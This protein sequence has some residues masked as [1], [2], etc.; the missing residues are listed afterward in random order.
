MSS[1][2]CACGCGEYRNMYDSRGRE[3]RYIKGHGVKDSQ[4]HFWKGGRIIREGYILILV[5]KHPNADVNGY[6]K[7]HRF[8]M[9]Q[10]LGR[11]L[12][13]DEDVHHINGIKDDNRMENLEL[14]KHS[15]HS[16]ITN[17]K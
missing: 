10:K 15:E 17:T 3:T 12:T 13:K 11:Y 4:N 7:E 16:R 5:R 14:L 1:I 2:L 8:I 9:E 6:V